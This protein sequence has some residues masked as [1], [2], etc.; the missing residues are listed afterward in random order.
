V[1]LQI[2]IALSLL[3][4]LFVANGGPVMAKWLLGD[5]L[6]FPLDGGLRFFDGGPLLGPSKTVRGLLVGVVAGA[7]VAP[8][9]NISW[10]LA[11]VFA[12]ASLVGD[13]LSSFA[14][15]RL[16]IPS[17]GRAVG[18][19]QIPEALLPLW[20]FREPLGLDVWSVLLLVAAFGVGG[21]ALSRVMFRFG[22]RDR[23][24]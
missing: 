22:L 14:K 20:L 10:R 11:A 3:L 12:L 18:L 1:T 8:L 9:V 7:A 4:L 19:D 13:A 23:P 16:R 21:T 17:S 5:R 2:D 24:Y 6:A 15:R